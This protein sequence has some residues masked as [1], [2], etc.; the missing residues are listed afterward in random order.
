MKIISLF[1]EQGW[2]EDVSYPHEQWQEEV[3]QEDTSLG[4]AQWLVAKHEE[5]GVTIQVKPESALE[6]EPGED[7]LE[8]HSGVFARE[9]WMNEVADLNTRLGY[10]A[11]VAHQV[12]ANE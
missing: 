2:K 7:F 10:G 12:D 4:Y 9:D 6:D 5:S 11:W 1:D 3:D 8:M